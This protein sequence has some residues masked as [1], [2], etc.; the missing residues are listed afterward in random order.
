MSIFRAPGSPLALWAVA[1]CFSAGRQAVAAEA[2]GPDAPVAISTVEIIGVAPLPGVGVERNLLPYAVQTVSAETMRNAPGDNLAEFMARNLTGVNINE[3]SGSP[4]QHDITF[5]GFRAS[6][7]LGTS[8]GLSVYLDGVRANEPF[9]D[10]V[11]WDMLPEAAIANAMLAPGSNPLYGLNTLGGAL[12]LTTKSGKSHPGLDATL[13]TSSAGQRRGDLAYGYQDGERIHAF[14][15]ST[16]FDDRGWRDQSAGHLGNLFAKVGGSVGATEW[17][18]ALLGG[19]SRLVGNGLL[20]S[21][22]VTDDG[23]QLGGLYEE[24]RRA[25]FTAPDESRN[26]LRQG[27]LTLTR[28]LDARSAVSANAY[29]RNSRRDTVNGD[30]SDNYGDYVEDCA[31]G[32]LTDGA[33]ADADECGYTR[34]QAAAL[35]AASFN[36]TSTRQRGRGLSMNVSSAGAAHKLLAGGSYDRSTVSFAQFEQEALFTAQRGV[37]ADPEEERETGSAVTGTSRI[38]ALYVSDTWSLND[39]AHLTLSARYNHA[40]VSNILSNEGEAQPQE[41]FVYRKF[42]PALGMTY[43][44]PG[45]ADGVTVFGNLSQN[46]RVPTVIE[47]GCADPLQPCRLPVGLQSDPYLKQVVSRTIEAGARWQVGAASSAALSLYRTV[48]RDDI[49]FR[50]AG[51]SQ[52]GYFANFARTRHQGVDL[53]V[54]HQLGN[55]AARVSYSYL[56]AAY[57]A[58]GLLFTGARNVQVTSGTRIAGLPRHT[59]KLGFDW[60][61]L[62]KLMLSADATALSNLVTQGNEDGLRADTEPGAAPAYADWRIRGYALLNLRA[63]YRPTPQWEVYGRINN[64][65]DRRYETFGAVGVDLFPNGQLVQPQNGPAEAELAR[66]VA[67]GAPRSFAAGVRYHF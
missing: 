48:N 31:D 8:Q 44:M 16:L 19:N 54:N 39:V 4:F 41:R 17:N 27:V 60:Q 55:L 35:H 11:S 5:H 7:V 1:L 37:I 62:P 24:N 36:T 34:A 29:V 14:V 9:G 65:A 22:R 43:D 20:P 47:L 10:I 46:N 2:P 64:L 38:W 50:S 57:G 18:L 25:T 56:D 67:P 3:I 51:V 15:A 61:A 40:Q 32:F 13:S 23:E 42:N 49:L 28:N 21:Y 26:R 53:A 12:V 52:Q 63:S 33:P 45:A 6:P 30:V 66:F 58:N 59:F